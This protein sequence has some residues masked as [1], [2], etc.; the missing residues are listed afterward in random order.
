MSQDSF[1]LKWYFFGENTTP[2]V[3]FW[4]SRE[5]FLLLCV[6]NCTYAVVGLNQ[7]FSSPESH[8]MLTSDLTQTASLLLPVDFFHIGYLTHTTT[9]LS[10]SFGF[11]LKTREP[12]R[13]SM[14]TDGNL[15]NEDSEIWEA[16]EKLNYR[17]GLAT[18]LS[19]QGFLTFDELL[20]SKEG[21][22]HE[23][24]S[25][26]D[27]LTQF[28]ENNLYRGSALTEIV[29]DHTQEIKIIP[30]GISL[31]DV[32]SMSNLPEDR[33]DHFV[34]DKEAIK[35]MA[36]SDSNENLT[37]TTTFDKYK[38][39]NNPVVCFKSPNTNISESHGN[40]Y[41]IE[42]SITPSSTTDFILRYTLKG[43]AKLEP[44]NSDYR[45]PDSVS[46]TKS[47]ETVD[48]PITIIN[49]NRKEGP[50]TVSITLISD[51]GYEVCTG[52]DEHILTIRDDDFEESDRPVINFI[53]SSSDALESEELHNVGITIGSPPSSDLI[54]RFNLGGTATR[55][56]DY[57]SLE[58]VTVSANQT[59]VNIPVTILG[60][61]DAE[62]NETIIL[63]LS[64][65]LDYNVGSIEMHTVTIIDDDEAE[66]PVVDFQTPMD[67]ISEDVGLHYVLITVDP[68][69]I[70]DFSLNYGFQ[71]T[72]TR[73]E[74]YTS[75]GTVR[76]FAQDTSVRIPL[77]IID[78]MM[79]EN[80]ETVT[81]TISD[82]VEYDLGNMS[83]HMLTILDN[84]GPKIPKIDFSSTAESVVE[85]VG[86]FNIEATITPPSTT[87]F[88]LNFSIEG[89]AIRGN[90]YKSPLFVQVSANQPVVEIPVNVIDD[91]IDETDETVI[92]NLIDG[93]EYDH[94]INDQYTLTIRDNDEPELPTVNFSLPLS[95]VPERTFVHEIEVSISPASPTGFSLMYAPT[96]GDATGLVDYITLGPVEVLGNLASVK[97]PFSIIDDE[98]DEEAETVILTISEGVGYRVGDNFEHTVTITDDDEFP[99]VSI[100]PE[101]AQEG[102]E[103]IQLSVR[104]NQSST[105]VITVEYIDME[106]EG[107]AERGSDYISSR[108][109]IIFDPGSTQG[110]IQF[111]LIDDQISEDE[112][113]FNVQILNPTKAK[114]S[115]IHAIAEAI[116][117]DDDQQA[118][119]RIEDAVVSEGATEIMFHVH[120]T[121]PSTAPVSVQYRTEDGT[122]TAGEDYKSVSGIVDFAPGT[123]VTSITVPLLRDD[124]DW[125][126][127]TFLV[128][129]ESPKDAR[130][131]KSLAVATIKETTDVAS[132]ALLAYTSRFIRTASVQVV[133]AIQ[134]RLRPLTSSCLAGQR[135]DAA[136]LWSIASVWNP[137]LGELLSDCK[138]S[139]RLDADKW[140]G[141]FSVWGRGAYR[142]FHGRENDALHLNGEVVSGMLGVD[143]QWKVGWLAGLLLA[144]HSGDGSFDIRQESGEVQAG[145][146]G[147]YPYISY[148]VADWEIWLSAGLGMGNTEI[149]NDSEHEVTSRFGAAGVQGHLISWNPA[150]LRYYGDILMTDAKIGSTALRADIYRIRLGM[151]GAFQISQMIQPYVD[152]NVR[153][154]GGSAETG[155]GIELGGGIRIA[156][157]QWQLRGEL[158]SQGLLI[159][160]VNGYTDWGISGSLQ[161][162]NAS[163]GFMATLRP[164]WGLSHGLS[165]YQQQTIL[166]SHPI[167][168]EHQ[169]TEIELGYGFTFKDGTVRSI[170]GVTDYS[171]GRLIRLGGELNP[172]EQF[173]ISVSGLALHQE[174][175]FR[176]Y[177]VNVQ[178]LIQY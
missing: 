10:L 152:A 3:F 7:A 53:L 178:G 62:G 116:I 103:E 32:S 8:Q 42:V 41:D 25:L 45:I 44:P 172:W 168:Q 4:R 121:Q 167:G 19:S 79:E 170:M 16:G 134:D 124:I 141:A 161:V 132:E 26:L 174:T 165:L 107:N 13:L 70:S 130:I 110:V 138:I 171:N 98:E 57:L 6:M 11:Y 145:L 21:Y 89:T 83:I 142:Q 164:S 96:G 105:E 158:H 71:G 112:E 27:E 156:V 128:H 118:E 59:L 169:R 139:K 2:R 78:D 68:A 151:E 15:L 150:K 51:E 136:R 100:H 120:L 36:N 50:E 175:T 147:V 31:N 54:L 177:G 101:E 73:G 39:L 61:T 127:E 119:I 91:M 67:R 69:P 115:E 144:H 149:I 92:F 122:A 82:G 133:E 63:T 125:R 77:Q 9:F 74:D 99:V 65:G 46:V 58:S 162:G 106:L 80:A 23:R 140:D 135:L 18:H 72:A 157:P 49:D 88:T 48:I 148:E 43:T 166:D 1:K 131:G 55:N 60:D 108:G 52:N 163:K 155:L 123:V 137:S 102:E 176:D 87:S 126:S 47:I 37:D 75:A 114:I 97:I 109:L 29:N 40:E 24:K 35:V 81:I 104:L 173:R 38:P 153:R 143:Y 85:D 146:T 113:K 56:S 93:A 154:D 20:I 95:T 14:N 111:T 64:E 5:I 34:K 159:H 90:D 129:L 33:N 22:R 17:R 117:I 76:V 12:Q 66:T 86:L 30:E 28:R 160:S 94:G 84:D